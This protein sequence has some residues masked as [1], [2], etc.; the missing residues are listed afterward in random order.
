MARITRIVTLRNEA[1][2][3]V[4]RAALEE[5]K[6]PHLVRTFHDTA[7]DGLYQLQMGW[8]TIEA[9]EEHRGAIEEIYADLCGERG[10]DGA[11]GGDDDGGGAPGA[12]GT[13]A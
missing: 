8:G 11:G 1:E 12:T 10:D 3:E 7:Y 6:I 13:N 4:M 5:R 2:A 9:D